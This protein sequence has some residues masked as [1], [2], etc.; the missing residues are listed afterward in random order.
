[1]TRDRKAACIVVHNPL[2][3]DPRVHREATALLSDGWSLDILCLRESG[4]P[5]D[6]SWHGARVFQLPVRRHRG[7]G[8]AVYMMEYAVFFLLATVWLSLLGL[9]RRYDLV[10]AHN[11]PDFLVFAALLPRLLGA[12]VLLDIRDPLPDLYASKFGG[13]NG[14]PMVRLTRWIEARSTAFADH[15]LTPGEPS[16][17]RLLGR[18]VSQD[19]V[20][21]ILNSA[22]PHL[23]PRT[24]PTDGEETTRSHFTLVYHGGLFERYG[25]DIAIRAV[26]R[27]RDDV[28]D[29]RFHIGGYGEEA[30][31]LKWLV[32]HLG[33]S[34]RVCFV[35]WI[36]AAQ[37]G[38]FVRGA[39]LGVVPYRRDTFTDLIYPTKA[40]EYIAM[41]VPVIMSELAGIAEL[42][43]GVDDAFFR[44]AD[45]DDLAR[46]ILLL[47]HDQRRLQRL[48]VAEE[49]AYA[50][51][52]WDGQRQEYLALVRRLVHSRHSQSRPP[53]LSA[54]V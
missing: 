49:K 10:Q 8:M 42:F 9:R 45:V 33:L 27:L 31:N 6:E 23:F 34:E 26:H 4:G 43:S 52:S 35:G 2:S 12:R 21:N 28:P 19:K 14:H 18:G 7:S 20:T 3:M 25:L 30:S 24:S 47:Y 17:R 39:S 54:G 46:H 53:R 38:A 44:P 51:Y 37:I 1:M 50:P 40:F 48:I 22:D 36:P 13:N 16:R 11:V 29:L 41:G 32:E 15:V 5:R